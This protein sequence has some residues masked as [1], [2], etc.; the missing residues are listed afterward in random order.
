MFFSLIVPIYNR[1]GEA[2]ELLESLSQQTYTDFEL[3]LIEDGS[4]LPCA[5]E[6]EKFRATVNINYIVKENSGRSDTRNAGMKQAKGEYFIFFD[7]DCIIPPRYLETV[8]RMLK[9]DYADCFG[10]PD[11]EHPSFSVM[12]K[13]INYA[14]TS[15]WTTGGIRGGKVN[16]EKF[17][18]RTFNM[19]FS[20]AVYEKVGGFKDMYGEDIDLSIRINKAGFTTKLYRGAFVYHKR[21]VSLKRFYKQVHIFG[22]AR[23]NLYKLYP[24]S[25]KPV[26]TLP[27]LFVL[28][29]IA[30]TVLAFVLSAWFLV[31]PAVYISLLFSDSLL[32]TKSVRIAGLSLIASFIQIFGYGF[33][34]ITSFI[35]KI[36]FRKGPED[37]ETIKK[38]YK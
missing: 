11:R 15:F 6:V 22:Q 12:Q 9:E 17:K 2:R 5:D 32:K 14:M 18:P 3:V 35:R 33:G 19:G 10:G 38:V 37:S 26:H 7:S 4:S 24:D 25:L 16:M 36:I 28:G 23:I 27:A 8:N 34:F 29:S 1:P 30:V 31:F 13:A 21:R 20:R